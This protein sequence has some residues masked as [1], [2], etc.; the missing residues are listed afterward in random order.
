MSDCLGLGAGEIRERLRRRE[1][2][3]LEVVRECLVRVEAL[4]GRLHAFLRL[5]PRAEEEARERDREIAAGAGGP[6]AGI[7]VAIKDNLAT[8]GL[9][10]TCGSRILQ[11]FVPL[12]DATA[13]ARLRTAGAVVL[14]KTNLDEFGMGSS[15]ENSAF[16]PTRNPWDLDRVPGGSSGG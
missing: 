7:P 4:D 2:S 13:V 6:L 11:D 16:G 15:T 5:N 9:T 10:T 14:G 12:S 1:V 3:A 8:A